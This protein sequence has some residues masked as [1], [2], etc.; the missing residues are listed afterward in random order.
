MA[1]PLKKRKKRCMQ[2]SCKL[3]ILLCSTVLFSPQEIGFRRRSTYRGKPLTTTYW[4]ISG[5]DSLT[6]KNW[7]NGHRTSKGRSERNWWRVRM[8][9]KCDCIVYRTT[10]NIYLGFDGWPVS[11]TYCVNVTSSTCLERHCI[12]C[13]APSL[14]PTIE[15]SKELTTHISMMF[16]GCCSGLRSLHARWHLLKL[17]TP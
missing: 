15:S 13:Q 5:N 10:L 6:M 8:A 11:W 16:S 12:L 17:W 7:R 14:G 4:P 9:C 2:I 3:V 1:R